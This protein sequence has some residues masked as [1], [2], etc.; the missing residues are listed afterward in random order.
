MII[1]DDFLSEKELAEYQ[2][3]CKTKSF[4]L[5][6]I[7]YDNLDKGS[8]KIIDFAK[9]YYDFANLN[10][11]EMWTNYNT[12]TPVLHTDHDM[13]HFIKTGEEKYPICTI[14][15]YPLVEDVIGGKLKIKNQEVEPKTNRLVCFPKGVPHQVQSFI[16]TRVS[17]VYNPWSY[18]IRIS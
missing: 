11:C 12:V 14:I 13:V 8:K 7:E 5:Q 15:F 4:N 1:K 18:D 6:T 17:V 3:M 10:I 16:G 2:N 9:Q